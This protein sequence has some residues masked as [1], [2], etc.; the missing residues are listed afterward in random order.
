LLPNTPELSAGLIDEGA[1]LLAEALDW[2]S[3]ERCMMRD[4]DADALWQEVYRQLSDFDETR[5]PRLA[6][7]L[8]RAE[9]QVTRVALIFAMLDCK[10]QIKA[11][12]LQSALAFWRYCEDSARWIFSGSGT[13]NRHADRILEA[14]RKNPGG[15]TRTDISSKVFNRNIGAALLDTAF[16]L[17]EKL[18]LARCEPQ[19]SGGRDAELWRGFTKETN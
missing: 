6:P 15:M 9:A 4:G 14:L 18:G 17:L 19:P 10:K 2:C 13:G 5:S 3:H 7:L 16:A 1:E 8:G 11:V 12:H